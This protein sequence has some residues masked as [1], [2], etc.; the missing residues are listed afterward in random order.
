[1]AKNI[2]SLTYK[3]ALDYFMS[4][5]NYSTLELPE[6]LDMTPILKHVR[7]TIGAKVFEDCVQGNRFNTEVLNYTMN[8]NKDGKYAVRPIAFVN[9]Y[10]YYFFAREICTEDNWSYLKAWFKAVQQPAVTACSLPVIAEEKE[11]FH[12]STTIL[13]W[14]SNFEQASLELSLEYPYMFI[15]DIRNCYGSINTNFIVEALNSHISFQESEQIKDFNQKRF[16]TNISNLLRLYQG[17]L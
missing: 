15:S 7:K 8:L 17:N 13:N 12:N 10:I 9:P 6:Y 2:L 11:A 4:A 1:M 3:D 16:V 14:W 5:S